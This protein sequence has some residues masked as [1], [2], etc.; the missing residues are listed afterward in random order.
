[1]NINLKTN[2]VKLI[3]PL[4][5]YCEVIATYIN[6]THATNRVYNTM[7]LNDCPASLWD[8]LTPAIAQAG[9]SD[10]F[11]ARLNGPR[12][13]L[14]DTNGP[15]D[16]AP[17][18][19]GQLTELRTFGGIDMRL[20]GQVVITI[21]DA[22]AGKFGQPYT[23]AQVARKTNW[24]YDQGTTAYFLTDDKGHKFIM[25]SYSQGVD[26]TLTEDALANLGSKLT[27]L[28]SG[29]SFSAVKL[30]KP[31]TLDNNDLKFALVMGDE[32]QNTYTAMD[33][34]AVLGISTG[35]GATTTTKPSS[36]K[37]GQKEIARHGLLLGF[38]LFMAAVNY[39]I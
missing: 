24:T 37:G 32:F 19:P 5:R 13:W 30:D 1:M 36:A 18:F 35:S 12:F 8:A 23:Y 25:Q 3:L 2:L 29:Y 4:C 28:P 9:V 31:I 20:A 6:I 27:K 16:P 38:F 10:A 11:Q 39:V 14:L 15:V 22:M 34:Q 26:K 7:G 17:L 21:A 33:P